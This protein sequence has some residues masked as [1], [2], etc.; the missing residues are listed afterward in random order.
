MGPPRD[1]G[2]V[3]GV[4]P[5]G[6]TPEG[7]VPLCGP[8]HSQPAVDSSR[9]K[10][11]PIPLRPEAQAMLARGLARRLHISHSQASEKIAEATRFSEA[12]Q[13]GVSS[14]GETAL[15]CWVRIKEHQLAVVMLTLRKW[16]DSNP[17]PGRE[18]T[19]HLISQWLALPA[20][21][22]PVYFSDFRSYLIKNSADSWVDWSKV[23]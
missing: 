11:D 2:W 12:C 4:A 6:E 14:A 5:P 18:V 16:F 10:R 21:E 17:A 20:D 15:D 8:V 13:C 23:R 1:P 7:Y 3:P 9:P 22:L 19:T